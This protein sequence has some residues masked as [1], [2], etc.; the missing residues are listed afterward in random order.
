MANAPGH[1][2]NSGESSRRRR[3]D[4]PS[5]SDVED[6]E[7]FHGFDFN[8]ED[9]QLHAITPI[10]G[11]HRTRSRTHELTQT[12]DPGAVGS[13]RQSIAD[14][15]LSFDGDGTKAL[16]HSISDNR[17]NGLSEQ[18]RLRRESSSI[19]SL[20]KSETSSTPPQ[21]PHHDDNFWRFDYFDLVAEIHRLGLD[22]E[23]ALPRL[24]FCGRQS[25]GKSS[26]LE[27]ITGFP[28]LR[29]D[30]PTVPFVTE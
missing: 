29:N 12:H 18:Q 6:S 7:P 21:R 25:S 1:R 11:R 9:K 24:V 5:P 4:R 8:G 10:H 3:V 26:V 20:R 27:A 23:M 2:G 17:N 28:S 14:Q 13:K 22:Q 30:I 15:D 16:S 19:T